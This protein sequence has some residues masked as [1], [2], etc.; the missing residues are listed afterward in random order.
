[1]KTFHKKEKIDIVILWVDGSDPKWLEEKNKYTNVKDERNINRYRDFDNLQYLFRGIEKYASWVNKIFFVTWGHLPKWLNIK[2]EKLR[3]V[4]HEDFIPK[5]YLPTFNSN[6][7]EMNLHRIEELSS[8]FILFND[9]L[10]ILNELKE[11]DFFENGLPKD[12]YIEYIKKN[13]SKRHQI[14]RENYLEIINKYFTKSEFIKNNLFKVFNIRYGLNNF[15]TLRYLLRKQFQD[16]YSEHLSQ[17]F[18]KSTFKE[19]WSKEE[20][21]LDE[22]CHNKFR[23]NTDIGNPICRYWQLLSGNF[24]PTS[25]LGKYYEI[26]NNNDMIIKAIRTQKY[27]LICINDANIDVDFEKA[28]KEINNAFKTIYKEKSSFEI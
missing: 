11:K 26:D 25:K 5:E 22:A 4:R 18:L 15:K 28:K 12:M 14:M 3:I 19:I 2:N 21:K 17:H 23:A 16:F 24:V 8:E 7:I 10:F 1:M 27:K 6:V 20:K 13:P 9:D